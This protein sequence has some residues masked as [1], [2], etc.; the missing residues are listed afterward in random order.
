[1][2]ASGYGPARVL[3]G[4]AGHKIRGVVDYERHRDRGRAWHLEGK[5]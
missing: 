1:M 3:D 5:F 2:S 4:A